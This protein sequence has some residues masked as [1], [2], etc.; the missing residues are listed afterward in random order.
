[1]MDF[2]VQL[3]VTWHVIEVIPEIAVHVDTICTLDQCAKE[4]FTF[5]LIVTEVRPAII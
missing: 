5:P 3:H 2:D 1:M 4:R